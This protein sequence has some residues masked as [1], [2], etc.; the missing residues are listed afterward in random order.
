MHLRR[1]LVLGRLN[2][3]SYRTKPIWLRRILICL[4]MELTYYRLQQV[5][6]RLQ[7]R[8][9][10]LVLC[11]WSLRPKTTVARYYQYGYG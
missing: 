1:T 5:L 8:V 10:R 4:R 6:G 2:L 7:V 11:I 3:S 9:A